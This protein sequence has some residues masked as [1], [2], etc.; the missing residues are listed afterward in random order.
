MLFRSPDPI[1]RPR[2]RDMMRLLLTATWKT[3]RGEKLLY[4]ETVRL[5]VKRNP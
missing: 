2:D 3:P 5:Q 4:F 1:D